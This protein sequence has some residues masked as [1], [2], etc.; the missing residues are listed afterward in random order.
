MFILKKGHQPGVY[1]PLRALFLVLEI[2]SSVGVLA[3]PFRQTKSFQPSC[4][5]RKSTLGSIFTVLNACFS[6]KIIITVWSRS[7]HV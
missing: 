6:F 1:V 4:H 5:S 3:L 7:M 2:R